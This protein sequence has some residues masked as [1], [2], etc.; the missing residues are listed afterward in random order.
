MPAPHK[1]SATLA[2][3]NPR[4]EVW[5]ILALVGM[6]IF[7][8]TALHLQAARLSGNIQH[9]RQIP[10]IASAL[11]EKP[12]SLLFIGN[13][14]TNNGIEPSVFRS[15]PTRPPFSAVGKVVPDG[16]ALADWYCIYQNRFAGLAN[17]PQAIVVGFA[18]YQLSDQERTNPSR[19]GGFFCSVPDI[20]TLVETGVFDHNQVLDFLAGAI[21]QVY[22]NREA[23]RNRVL[24]SLVPDYRAIAQSLNVN[25]DVQPGSNQKNKPE[26]S[27]LLLARFSKLVHQSHSKLIVVAMPVQNEYEIDAG[28]MA[29]TT[30]LGIVLIDMRQ[31]P[32][33]T[34]DLFLDPI[35]LNETGR[36]KFSAALARKLTGTFRHSGSG[37][38]DAHVMN[39]LRAAP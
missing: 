32:G 29:A 21:S 13:S 27:Y 19:L 34:H 5:L 36:M 22:V 28:L 4:H 3:Q 20:G 17:P 33:I 24:D 12:G 37:T 6:V 10:H 16:T 39:V 31:T 11:S 1:L 2:P 9:I 38:A 25:P 7:L 35:H 15:L 8:E 18:W 26:T 30:K 23:I 14:L